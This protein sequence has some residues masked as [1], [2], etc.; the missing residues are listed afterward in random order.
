MFTILHVINRKVSKLHGHYS[1]T[2]KPLTAK[3]ETNNHQFSHTY[4]AS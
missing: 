1:E 2:L 4:H 3:S